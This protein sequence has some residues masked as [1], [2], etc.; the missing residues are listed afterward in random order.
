[1]R[2]RNGALIAQAN[3]HVYK[4]AEM[5]VATSLGTAITNFGPPR[6][7]RRSNPGSGTSRRRVRSTVAVFW[8]VIGSLITSIVGMS[9]K[10][11]LTVLLPHLARVCVERVFH[12]GTSV[13]IKAK[14]T[15]SEVE[16]PGCGMSS[17]RKH[18]HYEWRLSDTA[19]GTQELL[20][21]LRVHRFFCHNDAC[22]KKTFVEQV[23]GLTSRY[24]RRSV[25]A[26]EALRAIALGLGGR[27]SPATN[28]KTKG[29]RG[30][31]VCAGRSSLLFGGPQ[32]QVVVQ[33]PGKHHWQG[34]QSACGDQRPKCLVFKEPIAENGPF[35]D[36][37]SEADPVRD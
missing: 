7:Q 30:L 11:L 31:G 21:D 5:C 4:K 12:S 13:R 19:I 23:P 28:R 14:T 16:C 9:I 2:R 34:D 35:P 22:A 29:L 18:S 33:S 1:M 15:T 25:V 6:C 10:E 20:I 17:R 26:G 37:Q 27:S 24:G 36:G 3:L 8:P 32:L